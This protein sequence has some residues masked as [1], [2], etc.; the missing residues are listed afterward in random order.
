LSNS[1][2]SGQ[3][4]DFAAQGRLLDQAAR[5]QQAREIEFCQGFGAIDAGQ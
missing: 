2:V 3:Q 4:A 1:A 5:R